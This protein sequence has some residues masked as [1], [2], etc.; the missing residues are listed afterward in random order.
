MNIYMAWVGQ[1]ATTGNPHPVTGRLSVR[2][3]LY[4]FKSKKNRDEFCDKWNKI[5]NT[6]PVPTNRKEAKAKYFA[7]MT[8]HEYDMMIDTAEW[9]E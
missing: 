5:Y 4:I 8:Q 7:G 1:N 3:D 9:Y 2:G 6:Y